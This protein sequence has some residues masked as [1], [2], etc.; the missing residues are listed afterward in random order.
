VTRTH[1][2]TG[3]TVRDY[4]DALSAVPVR[5]YTCLWLAVRSQSAQSVVVVVVAAICHNRFYQQ[6][7]V[8]HMAIFIEKITFVDNAYQARHSDALFVC[9]LQMQFVNLQTLES[10]MRWIFSIC[11]ILPAA[12]WPWGRLSL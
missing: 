4:K 8:Y 1:V 6:E 7:M 10:R 9:L 12:L 3:R 2:P 11:L 5:N